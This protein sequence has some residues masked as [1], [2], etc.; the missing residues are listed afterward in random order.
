MLPIRTLRGKVAVWAFLILFLLTSTLPFVWTIMQSLKTNLQ[1]SAR[2]PLIF[3]RPTLAN[4]SEI[5][6]DSVDTRTKVILYALLALGVILMLARLFASRLPW[7]PKTV[8]LTAAVIVG[9]VLWGLP[10][11]IDTAPLYDIFLNSLIVAGLTVVITIVLTSISGYA[12]ARYAGIAAVV[13]LLAAVAF[14]ALPRLGFVLPYF[15]A[16][17]RTG[18]FD[19]KLLVIVTL[20]ALNLPFAMWLLRGFFRD[21]PHEL[22]E[23]AMIDGAGRFK[24]FRLVIVP[25]AWPG[26]IATGLFTLL[27]AYQEFLLVRVITQNNTT[28][29][30]AGAQFLGGRGVASEVA[31]QSAAAVSATLPLLIVV[32]LY[33]KHL[34]K[35]LSAGAVK[36]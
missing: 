6:L 11:V 19:T 5:W 21:I 2:T 26:I 15:W 10:L 1:A 18:L 8:G 32:M 28:L 34:V 25:I 9:I 33:Q 16:G 14:R 7:P 23:S 17:Q 27:V 35:G 12:L 20:V 22:E 3:F 30:V 24:A 4:Y 13:V 36:G 29:A 31:I